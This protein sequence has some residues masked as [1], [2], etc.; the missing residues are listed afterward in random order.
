MK[1][2]SWQ[3]LTNYWIFQQATFSFRRELILVVDPFFLSNEAFFEYVLIH[4]STQNDSAIF[5]PWTPK[6]LGFTWQNKWKSIGKIG[7]ATGAL[8]IPLQKR[9]F[10]QPCWCLSHV[11]TMIHVLL[12]FVLGI[13]KN[14]C[15]PLYT[16]STYAFFMFYEGFIKIHSNPWHVPLNAMKINYHPPRSF[17]IHQHHH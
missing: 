16:Q 4:I 12:S 11:L 8:V 6:I 7:K 3:Y 5:S 14:P 9:I 10:S 2:S 17:Q 13:M 15:V 1:V